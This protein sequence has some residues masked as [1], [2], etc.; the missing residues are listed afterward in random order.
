M[1]Q[2]PYETPGIPDQ[3]FAKGNSPITRAEIRSVIIAK[4]RLSKD[5][6]LWDIG[7]GTG[8]VAIEA[9]RFLSAG[10][11]WAVEAAADRVGLIAENAVKFGLSN[12]KAIRGGAP[13]VLAEL[14]VADRVFI[15]GSGGQLSEIIREAGRRLNHGGRLVM[16]AVTLENLDTGIKE[17]SFAPFQNLEVFSF[18]VA[19]LTSLNDYHL[20]QPDHSI[21]ILTAEIIDER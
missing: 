14:P 8:S 19:R 21:Y 10:T 7:S 12:I 15:G 11:V 4:L 9:A 6:C 3:L 20:F 2:W 18:S 16:S 5:N 17:L 13:R 1:K